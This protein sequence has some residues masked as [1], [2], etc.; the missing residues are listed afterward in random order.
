MEPKKFIDCLDSLGCSWIQGADLGLTHK[1]IVMGRPRQREVVQPQ[2][3]HVIVT[4]YAAQARACDW[5]GI[6]VENRRVEHQ[7][8]GITGQKCLTC[9]VRRK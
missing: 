9:G 8:Q 2:Q 3:G 6:L 7:V 5:C 1:N 4:A